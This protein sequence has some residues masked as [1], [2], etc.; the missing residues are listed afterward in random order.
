MRR[1]GGVIS[2]E[3]L[4]RMAGAGSGRVILTASGG[5]EVA[6]ESSE[7]GHGV[8]TYYLL[9]GLRGAADID[10]DGRVDIDEIYKYVSQKVS[11]ATHG[12]QNPMRKSPNLSGTIVLGGNVR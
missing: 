5:R 12:R 1:R 11:S 7:I 2:E 10:H 4:S 8:F 3:F 9:E 6:Q